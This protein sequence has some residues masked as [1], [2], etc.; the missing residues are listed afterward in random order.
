[1]YRELTVVSLVNSRYSKTITVVL[2]HLWFYIPQ[3]Q[4]H[5]VNYGLKILTEKFQ[6]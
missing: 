3:F 5:M 2:T 6:R 4:L 1:M